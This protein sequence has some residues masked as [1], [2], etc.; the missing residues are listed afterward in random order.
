M[1]SSKLDIEIFYTFEYFDDI[2][3]IDLHFG[4]R[5]DS[6]KNEMGPIFFTTTLPVTLY[7]AKPDRWKKR[8]MTYRMGQFFKFS[9]IYTFPP[10]TKLLYD[11]EKYNF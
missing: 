11:K 3:Y 9:S 7:F 4:T 5:T 10:K 1:L 2:L 6:G 8:S